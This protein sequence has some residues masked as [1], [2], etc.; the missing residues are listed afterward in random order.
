MSCFK[1]AAS[2]IAATLPLLCLLSCTPPQKQLIGTATIP[3]INE[4]LCLS[5]VISEASLEQLPGW[6][7][8]PR[9]QK[10]LLKNFTDLHNRLLAEFRRCQ[11]FGLY[12]VVD[13]AEGPTMRIS[14]ALLP[15]EFENDTLRMPVRLQ[16][17]HLPDGQRYIYT[18]S[19]RGTATSEAR[20]RGEFHYIGLLLADYC[21]NFPY[22][23][24]VSFFYP[25]EDDEFLIGRK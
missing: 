8:D 5:R 9:Q 10:I 15:Y 14:V 11:K 24:L 2:C 17:E 13:D 12:Q 3:V 1:T 20:D 22:K 23:A 21:R 7:H 16:T 6:P 19:A 18:L 25:H 4:R